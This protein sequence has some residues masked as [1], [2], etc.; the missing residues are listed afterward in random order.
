M[1]LVACMYNNTRIF[2]RCIR[3]FRWHFD[4]PHLSLS[5]EVGH[6]LAWTRVVSAAQCFLFDHTQ[7]R[8]CPGTCQRRTCP[9]TC[10]PAS[11]RAV[12]YSLGYVK[13]A[14]AFCAKKLST[15]LVWARLEPQ[16]LPESSLPIRTGHLRAAHLVAVHLCLE[17][18]NTK[19]GSSTLGGKCDCCTGLSL[20]RNC[21]CCSMCWLLCLEAVW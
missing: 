2:I 13:T 5:G 6:A 19:F 7:R 18:Q 4:L 8:T 1:W 11:S 16:R 15:V 17:L 10:L 14:L 21:R 3:V 9:G 20:F 12:T